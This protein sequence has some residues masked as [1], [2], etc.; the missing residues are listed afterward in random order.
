M[1]F[2]EKLPMHMPGH[3]RNTE[4]LGNDLPYGIDIT[5][6][7]GLDDLH[8][9]RGVLLNT[10]HL[11][12]RLYG[13]ARAFPMVNG[14]TGGILAAVR[15]VA[16][17]VGGSAAISRASHRSVYNALE[18]CRLTPVYLEQTAIADIPDLRCVLVTSPSY[19]GAVADVEAIA[20]QAHARGVP[21]IVDAAH[22]AH[23]GFSQKFPKNATRL[24]ADIEIVSLHK[25]LPALTQCALALVSGDLVDSGDMERALRVFE[26]SSPS[27]V[28]LESIDRALRLL[29]TRGAEIFAAY[30]EN[31]SRFYARTGITA[32]DDPGKIVIPAA[33]G[34]ALMDAFREKYDIELEMCGVDYALAM[35]SIADTRATLD[36]LADAVIAERVAYA[37]TGFLALLGM[38]DIPRRVFAPFDAP[39]GGEFL[40][41]SSAV[42]RVALE[43]AW[44]YPPGVPIIVPGEL[45][46]AQTV[47][48]LDALTAAGIEPRSD[49]GRLPELLCS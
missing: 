38:T 29:D 39:R 47:A 49:N 3:K 13:A 5:E 15:A 46:D 7:E 17:S 48:Q 34:K 9:M 11:A 22:G 28:L 14:S 26:T 45:I 33:N 30:E 25:T 12:A 21:L 32:P 42:G 6:I 44:A 24:G 10:A 35:T 8:N 4:L 2:S 31:L 20:A 1:R 18:L 19:L 27:Y 40:P 37:A 41:Y 36:R 43:Y 16:G 23:F